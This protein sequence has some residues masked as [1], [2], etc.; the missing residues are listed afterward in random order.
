MAYG[1]F[2]LVMCFTFDYN[3][4]VVV[5]FYFCARLSMI[6]SFCVYYT[7]AFESYPI[8][9]ANYGYSLNSATCSI[10]GIVIPFII[11]YLKEKYVFLIYG[12]FG[13][14][15]TGMFFFLK[16]TRGMPRADNIKEIEEEL[17]RE[18]KSKL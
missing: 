17:E 9:V 13:V 4:N 3:K 15:C 16:E 5:G 12:I 2:C 10:A 6:C 7:Y 18:K 1:I 8:S 14:V 11:E